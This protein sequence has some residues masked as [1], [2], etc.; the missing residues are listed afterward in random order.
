MEQ[1]IRTINRQKIIFEIYTAE[2]AKERGIP[3]KHWKDCQPGE[4]GLS[5]DGYVG[6][7]LKRR[8]YTNK[9]K[10]K[11][12]E[13][14]F[15]AYGGSWNGATDYINFLERKENNT[16]SRTSPRGWREVEASSA[17]AKVAIRLAV[18]QIIKT[19]KIDYDA[20]GEF[21][22]PEQASPGATV[23]RF[24]KIDRVRKMLEEALQ[25]ALNVEGVTKQL[26]I[27][28]LNTAFDMAEE[29]KDIPNMLRSTE[30]FVDILQMK[31]PTI[32]KQTLELEGHKVIAIEGKLEEEEARLVA[33]KTT[34]GTEV[35]T[36][37]ETDG[38][39]T[40]EVAVEPGD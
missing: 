16:Y 38:R 21:Y 19:G 34:I 33:S 5:D 32:V 39:Q 29:K 31:K 14:I 17:R 20:I 7:C 22:R 15:M 26:V 4:Y 25:E 24:F 8:A 23:K 28:R 18:D 30:N 13:A 9:L 35:L 10:R 40:E 12:R 11:T 36:E 1:I 3:F 2:E 37:G 27:Q 6:V